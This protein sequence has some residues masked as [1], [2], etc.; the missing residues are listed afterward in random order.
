MRALEY[1]GPGRAAGLPRTVEA[2]VPR[3]G[4][5]QVLV[6]VETAG[7]PPVGGAPAGVPGL[8]FAGVVVQ[9]G[10]GTYG[11]EVGDEVLGHCPAGACA[12]YVAAD[13]DRVTHRPAALLWAEAAV[14]PVTA[15]GV[16]AALDRLGVRRGRTLLVH[17]AG[18]AAGRA[19]VSL[20]LRRGAA[21]LAVAAEREHAALREAGAVP[22][23]YGAQLADRA[24]AAAPQGVDAVLDAVGPGTA[25]LWPEL[26]GGP[27]RVAAPVPPPGGRT[28]GA[29]E[30][31]ELGELVE[32]WEEGAF[33]LVPDAVLG[34][35][36][37]AAHRPPPGG[38][39]LAVV[40]PWT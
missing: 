36:E 10:P 28:V 19:A 22:I 33:R 25:T 7:L 4:P 26:A 34:L 9:L 39:L 14:L 32:L 24:R 11:L 5:G 29:A 17:G 21:V 30:S 23:G 31:A 1:P 38:G 37:A 8:E 6:R 3:P 2:V 12:E 13:A 16:R 18:A 40:A 27:E 15:A 20:A 35:A